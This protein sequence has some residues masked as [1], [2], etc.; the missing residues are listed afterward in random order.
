[1]PPPASTMPKVKAKAIGWCN[2]TR[3]SNNMPTDRKN[4]TAKASRRGSDSSAARC[5][6][7]EPA[8]IMPPKKAPSAMETPNRNDAANATVSATDSTARRNNSRE[9]VCA[10]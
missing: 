8:K 5:D 2:T 9:P 10:M 3:G 6:N 4:S 1:M 7:F